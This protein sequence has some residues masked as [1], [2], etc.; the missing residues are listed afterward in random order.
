MNI[1]SQLKNQYVWYIHEDK[2]KTETSYAVGDAKWSSHQG[3][4]DFFRK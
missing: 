2:E 1:L 3:N 4:W